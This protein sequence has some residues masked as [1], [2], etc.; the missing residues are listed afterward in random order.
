MTIS[1]LAKTLNLSKSTVS[2]ALNNGPK[3]VSPEVKRRVLE[4][5]QQLGYRPNPVARSL[6][7][8][9]SRT[10]GFIP[11]TLQPATMYSPFAAHMLQSVFSIAH[12]RELHVLLPSG[13]DPNRANETRE[14][15]FN[16]PV[17]G[18]I[19]LVPENLGALR[20]VIG[21]GLPLVAIAGKSDGLIPAIN[22]DNA[23]GARLAF[24][25]LWDLGHRKIAYLGSTDHTDTMLRWTA[26]KEQML[27]RLGEVNH[28]WLIDSG[29]NFNPIASVVRPLLFA[30]DRPTAIMCVNDLVASAVLRVAHELGM[31]V[32]Q[33]LSVI[34]FDDDGLARCLPIPL[35]TVRQPISEMASAAVDG[36]MSQI[37][38][39]AVSDLVLPTSLIVRATTS[40]PPKV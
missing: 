28:S 29:P 13:Y 4:A 40:P 36:V 20:D 24:D 38:G 15:L 39:Q 33:D 5:A 26:V 14:H 25:H 30:S 34:G 6:A 32:P 16:A 2:Y 10:I 31:K 27:N 12:D 23:G 1:E 7:Q 18:F 35:S 17:D 11:N 3:P 21:R 19:L 37:E 8:K 9:R 22:A